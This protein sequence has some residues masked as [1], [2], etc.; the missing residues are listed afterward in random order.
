MP[1]NAQNHLAAASDSQ[2][3]NQHDR[4]LKC[5]LLLAGALWV[6]LHGI[7]ERLSCVARLKPTRDQL[8]LKSWKTY[9]TFQS[10][11]TRNSR[12][13]T[14]CLLPG[15][16]VGGRN[17]QRLDEGIGTRRFE[18]RCDHGELQSLDSLMKHG[19]QLPANDQGNAAAASDRRHRIRRGPPLALTDLLCGGLVMT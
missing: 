3:Q 6:S 12:S 10:L 16:A 13:A 9:R 8:S 17:A 2:F 15:M 18:K 14:S 7:E 1:Y 11:I 5:I 19:R 4:R